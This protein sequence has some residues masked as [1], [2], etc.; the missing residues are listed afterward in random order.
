MRVNNY[1]LFNL[2]EALRKVGPSDVFY[3]TISPEMI[4]LIDIPNIF[5]PSL[6]IDIEWQYEPMYWEFKSRDVSITAED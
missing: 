1:K 4:C 3:L 6:Q 5:R 2:G